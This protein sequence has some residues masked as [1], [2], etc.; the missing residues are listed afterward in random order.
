MEKT[1]IYILIGAVIF[2]FVVVFYLIFAHFTKSIKVLVPNGA[3]EWEIGQTY[4]ITWDSKRIERVGI[5]LFNGSEPRWIAQNV[6][7]GLGSYDWKIYPGQAYGDNYTIAVFE[8]PW[9]KGNRIDFSNKTFAVVYP[10]MAT[11]DNISI[12][13]EWPYVASNLPNL[14]RVFIT[15][16]TFTGNLNGLEGADQKCQ[17]EA[18]ER[19]LEG[20]WM[21]F[22]G[23]EKD[24][25][26]AIERLK[27]A[28]RKTDGVFINA[29]AEATLI[30]GD[31]CHRLLGKNFNQFLGLFSDVSIINEKKLT[32]GFLDDLSNVWLGRLDSRSKKNC[33]TIASALGPDK[34]LQEQYSYTTSCQNWTKES[35]F[36]EGYPS[37]GS[38]RQ[39][40]P[41]CYTDTGGRLTN[42]VAMGGMGT[43]S[44]SVG[45]YRDGELITALSAYQGAYCSGR[46]KLLCVEK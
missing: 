32:E 23:G 16:N 40:F 21:A 13:K 34:P 45:T 18:E 44:F 38:A 14:R 20:Q 4:Q 41:T 36:V 9:R 37:A 7:S 1:L 12:E 25:E 31:T 11:C 6:L 30:R 33:T 5:V 39:T 43:G 8:Y 17:Q 29:E 2:S 3:E 46:Q 19:S 35:N 42:A 26:L 28:P 10:P 15:E 22:L 24:E 27:L